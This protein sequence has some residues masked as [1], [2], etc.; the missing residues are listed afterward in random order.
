MPI[1][2]YDKSGKEH[3]YYAFE[4]KDEKGKRK[5]I[6][7]RGFKGKTEARKAEAEAR[8][9]WEKGTHID[10]SR[11]LYSDYVI[12][13]LENKQDISKKTR[14]TNEGHLKNHIIPSLGHLPLQKIRVDHIES[15]IK[16]IQVK[17]LAPG[18][19]KKIFNLVQTSFNAAERK[20]LISKNPFNLLDKSSKPKAG[21]PK[22][23]Y[24]TKEEVK[25][26]LNGFEHR[27]KIIF[28][29]AIYTGM[30]QGEILALRWRDVDFEAKQ[31]RVRQILDYDGKIEERVKTDAGYRSVTLSNH[32]LTELKK[33]R[34]V[35]LQE[36]LSCEEY[37]D[38]D[39]VVCQ[40]NGKPVSKSNFHKF[41]VRRL[42][43]SE[44][45]RI[46]FHD[47]RHT[48][49][50]LLFSINTHP[51]VVQELLGH[52][53]I[54]ITMDTYSHMLPNMQEDAVNELDEM[55]K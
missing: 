41:W 12:K 28:T 31:L 14:I 2:P 37:F 23:D 15:F 42:A 11:M 13:W 9:A 39:L 27:N 16:S 29:L 26:F 52:Q 40:Q 10:A 34:T 36:K 32:V 55:L 1:Y 19:V 44:V 4:V 51:K 5:T 24:W 45:R 33:H 47:L 54:K 22:V 50:S 3:W 38:N 21:K 43:K 18:T 20:E 30:R 8:V 6:K 17:G 7:K 49:A 53:S 48:C 46:R 35:I 25:Q